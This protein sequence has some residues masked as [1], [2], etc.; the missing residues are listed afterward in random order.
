[1]LRLL[2]VVLL[3]SLLGSGGVAAGLV[4]DVPSIVQAVFVGCLG[5]FVVLL[6]TGALKATGNHVRQ[7]GDRPPKNVSTA[8]GASRAGLRDPHLD[9]ARQVPLARSASD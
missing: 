9:G 1:M 4:S 8:I 3:T 7:S 2:V 6:A 5:L